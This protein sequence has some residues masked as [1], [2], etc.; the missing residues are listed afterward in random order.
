MVLNPTFLF[1]WQFFCS[2][3][4]VS[5]GIRV[6]T[7]EGGF[8]QVSFVPLQGT[9]LFLSRIWGSLRIPASCG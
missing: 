2:Q 6:C 5:G 1:K 3:A 7:K 9:L 8:S 4:L